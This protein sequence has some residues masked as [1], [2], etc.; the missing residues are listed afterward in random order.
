MYII[1]G[2]IPVIKEMSPARGAK[3][4]TLTEMVI[5]FNR[6]HLTLRLERRHCPYQSVRL[7]G[8]CVAVI[9]DMLE[10]FASDPNVPAESNRGAS[11]ASDVPV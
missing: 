5:S 11:L 10:L 4:K 1:T 8:A 7:I 6:I 2:D 9:Q 3:R